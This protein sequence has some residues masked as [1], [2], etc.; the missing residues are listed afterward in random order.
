MK[1]V[2]VGRLLRVRDVTREGRP[3]VTEIP[4]RARSKLALS[5]GRTGSG[6]VE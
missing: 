2:L 6:N 3:R 1:S 4:E 5:I